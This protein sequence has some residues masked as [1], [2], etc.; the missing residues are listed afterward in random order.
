MQGWERAINTI[1]SPEDP[2]RTTS[3]HRMKEEKGRAAGDKK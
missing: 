3:T 2:N 1:F